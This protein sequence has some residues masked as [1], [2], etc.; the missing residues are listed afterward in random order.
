MAP[1]GIDGV[2]A[3]DYKAKSETQSDDLLVIKS[4]LR[5]QCVGVTSPKRMARNDRWVSDL[6]GEEYHG[7]CEH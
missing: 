1:P 7:A 5:S 2:T 6:M 4:G 3:T